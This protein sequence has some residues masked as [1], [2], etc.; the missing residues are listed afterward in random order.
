VYV[1]NICVS[2]CVYYGHTAVRRQQRA[3][4]L[5]Q[6]IAK[7]PVIALSMLSGEL[8]C[9]YACMYVC[10]YVYTYVCVRVRVCMYTY[11]CTRMYVV[12]TYV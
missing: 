4:L 8:L 10:M 2:V 3:Y 11:V 1:C 9:M 6:N 7:I 12:Y 5:T